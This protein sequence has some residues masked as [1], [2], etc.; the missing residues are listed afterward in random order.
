VTAT[1]EV[2]FGSIVVGSVRVDD[3]GHFAFT[4]DATWCTREIRFPVSITL[5][6]NKRARRVRR[7]L[8]A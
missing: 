8:A 6:I 2:R 5:P 3:G 1:L 7:A 4:Y